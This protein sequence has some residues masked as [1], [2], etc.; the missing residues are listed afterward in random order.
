MPWECYSTRMQYQNGKKVACC[1]SFCWQQPMFHR[2]TSKSEGQL[3]M[4]GTVLT[5]TLFTAGMCL[6]KMQTSDMSVWMMCSV[7]DTFECQPTRLTEIVLMKLSRTGSS[8]SL[9]WT[10]HH[11]AQTWI[12]LTSISSRNV[13][14]VWPW[15]NI[16]HSPWRQESGEDVLLP[17]DR[18]VLSWWTHVNFLTVREV[19]KRWKLQ[20]KV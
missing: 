12:H 16:L 9:S 1:Y 11:A 10:T 4:G 18:T 15:E 3:F 8:F 2:L 6:S 13:S 20:N 5:S 17:K 14:Y 7:E 19:V